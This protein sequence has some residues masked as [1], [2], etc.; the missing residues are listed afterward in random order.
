MSD[1]ENMI[2]TVKIGSEQVE[3]SLSPGTTLDGIRRD[4]HLSKSNE[5]STRIN[6]VPVDPESPSPTLQ[7][8]DSVVQVKVSG[9]QG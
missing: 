6:G 2:V 3:L 7:D 4:G 8:G 9:V 5:A 1:S